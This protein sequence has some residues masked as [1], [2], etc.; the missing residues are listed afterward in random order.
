MTLQTLQE[1]IVFTEGDRKYQLIAHGIQRALADGSLKPGD[2]LPPQRELADELGVTLGTV[3]RAYKELDKLGLVRGETG[4]GTFIAIR[5]IEEFTLHS[6]HNRMEREGR[7]VIRFDLNFPVSEVMPDLGK[8]LADLSRRPGLDELLRYQPTAGLLR[9]RKAACNYLLRVGLKVAP[10]DVVITT[11]AQHAIFTALASKLS[12]GDCVAVDEYTYPGILNVAG[13]LHLR[14][15][16]VT[17]D[18]EG[19]RPDELA[20]VAARQGVKGVYLIPTMHNPTTLTMGDDRRRELAKIIRAHDLFL[21]EDDVYGRMEEELW[22]PIALMIPERSFYVTNLSKTLAPG[23]RVGYM[24]VPPGELASVERVVASTTWMNPPLVCE[25][26]SRWIEDGTVERVLAKKKI[27]VRKRI[28]ILC[29]KLAPWK[30][31]CRP[32]GL[33]GWLELPQPWK[34]E[35]FARQAASMGVQVVPSSSFA[36]HGNFGIE[37]VRICV[38]PPESEAEVRRGA[39]I[40]ASLLAGSRAETTLIM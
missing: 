26:A 11:G 22:Q 21:V 32:S 5:E 16:P 36:T 33:H 31:T 29:D 9:H 24:T 19:M 14:L 2:Q 17:A 35:T 8:S 25:V 34:S 18:A 38:G 13:R 27:V 39:E 3:T 12:P 7:G 1:H 15:I 30:L 4:R 37:A 6:L 28:S 23:L 40:L 20:N 10:E